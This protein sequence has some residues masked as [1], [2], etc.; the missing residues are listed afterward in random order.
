MIVS[1][2]ILYYQIAVD[3]LGMSE[4]TQKHL[5]KEYPEKDDDIMT[6]EYMLSR[7]EVKLYLIGIDNTEHAI[8][9]SAVRAYMFPDAIM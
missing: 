7:E 1:A 6:G 3:G 9:I 8:N 4:E 5:F 2:T